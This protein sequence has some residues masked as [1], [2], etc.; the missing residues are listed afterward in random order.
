MCVG[1][2]YWARPRVST[3][4]TP[5]RMPPKRDSTTPTSIK[6]C[7]VPHERDIKMD[8]VMREEALE[9]FRHWI[10]HPQKKEY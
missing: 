8:Q 10:A 3:T 9:A 1:A 2:I 4:R 6:S 7:S 5:Q